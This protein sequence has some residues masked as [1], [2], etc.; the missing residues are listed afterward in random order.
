MIILR[1][2]LAAL[3]LSLSSGGH[4]AILKYGMTFIA[5]N[6]WHFIS[7]TGYL[8]AD[9]QKDSVI[10]GRMESEKL[11]FQWLDLNAA[12]LEF[13]DRYR[14]ADWIR[15]GGGFPSLIN[16]INGEQGA[17]D[18]L[19]F[20][21]VGPEGRK[22]Y[23]AHLDDNSPGEFWTFISFPSF[24]WASETSSGQGLTIDMYIDAPV[25]VETATHSVPEP[26]TLSLLALGLAA[27]GI[28]R[29]MRYS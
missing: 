25:L 17:F 7:G 4:S 24:Y 26:A 10:G 6:P 3:L 23:A 19:E 29:R 1:I 21:I 20:L 2:T 9:T 12:P 27:I 8:F 15:A 16:E 5:S 14:D 13:Q 22:P 11:A 28:R 18:A